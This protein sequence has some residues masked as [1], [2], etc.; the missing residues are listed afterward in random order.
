M[1]QG[2]QKQAVVPPG[3]V[4]AEGFDGM[5]QDRRSFLISA[6][7]DQ[8][9][10]IGCG[11]AEIVR[12]EFIGLAHPADRFVGIAK[13]RVEVAIGAMRVRAHRPHLNGTVGK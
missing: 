6:G 1:H 12:V 10:A 8:A 13:T 2:S 4:A 5:A 3:R 7:E 9:V 11:H